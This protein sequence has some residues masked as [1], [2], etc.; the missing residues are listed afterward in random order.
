MHHCCGHRVFHRTRF[1]SAIHHSRTV[2]AR[3]T[4]ACHVS[5]WLRQLA[6]QF[7]SCH[8]VSKHEGTVYRLA[9]TRYSKVLYCTLYNSDC[10]AFAT[11][12]L[13]YLLPRDSQQMHYI[14]RPNSVF[15]IILM[16]AKYLSFPSVN[17][18]ARLVYATP[19]PQYLQCHIIGFVYILL[20]PRDLSKC[21]SCE[22]LAQ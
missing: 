22:L 12:K 2:Q 16:A 3:T 7:H 10:D 1:H 17:A 15:L 19:V 4:P 13:R 20:S 8:D 21:G 6:L 11:R 18:R 14:T 9:G 5:G